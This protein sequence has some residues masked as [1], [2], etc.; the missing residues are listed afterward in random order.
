MAGRKEMTWTY[1]YED[2]AK[3][4]GRQANAIHQA[5]SRGTRGVASGFNPESFESVVR[6]VFRNA[7]DDFKIKLLAEMN[8]FRTEPGLKRITKPKKPPQP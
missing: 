5:A 6:W 7:T 2:L 3:L 8:F 1:G 4:T